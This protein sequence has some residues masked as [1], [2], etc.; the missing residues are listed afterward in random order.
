MSFYI[1]DEDGDRERKESTPF[2]DVVKND[3]LGAMGGA[4]SSGIYSTLDTSQRLLK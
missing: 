1:T 3:G 4:Q 2:L